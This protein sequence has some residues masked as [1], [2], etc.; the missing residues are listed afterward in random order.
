MSDREGLPE[1]THPAALLLPWYLSG[2]LSDGERASVEAHLSGCQACR[3][4]LASLAALRTSTRAMIES[5]S[6]PSPRVRNEV[7]SRIRGRAATGPS[8]GGS[9][10]QLARWSRDLLAPKW[11]PTFAVLLILAQLGTLTS[12]WMHSRTPAPLAPGGLL[13]RALAPSTVRLRIVFNPSA[14]ARDIQE[15]I[16]SLQGHIVD[17]PAADGAYVV[18]LAPAGP[19]V[20]AKEIQAL[21]GRP[22]LVDRLE[23]AQ[24]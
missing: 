13:P 12:L 22:G 9:L 2:E 14:S 20:I 19:Q 4:E 7:L 5:A 24:P 3:E 21:R 16:R 6:P 10:D 18:E 8:S 1:G 15:G 11:A 17:G 23:L